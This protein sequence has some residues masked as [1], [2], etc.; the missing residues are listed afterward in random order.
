MTHYN[1][2]MDVMTML[3]PSKSIPYTVNN[4]FRKIYIIYLIYIL[5]MFH[6]N[7]PTGD[8]IV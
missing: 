3:I 4:L 6:S 8:G 2:V 5:V 7:N 1:I